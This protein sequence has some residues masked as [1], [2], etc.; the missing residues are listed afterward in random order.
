MIWPAL[1]LL[2]SARAPAAD[3]PPDV[4]PAEQLDADLRQRSEEVQRRFQEQSKDIQ[5]RFQAIDNFYHYNGPSGHHEYR[6]DL[7]SDALPTRQF[8]SEVDQAIQLKYD[9]LEAQKNKR[10]E[11]EIKALEK[12]F[13][14][15]T[16]I[17]KG[18][19]AGKALVRALEAKMGNPNHG[20]RAGSS[21]T[22]DTASSAHPDNWG[23]LPQNPADPFGYI[24]N[25]NAKLMQND[26]GAAKSLANN[27]LALD[28]RDS[29]AYSLRAAAEMDLKDYRAA[30]SDAKSAID[31]NSGDDRS[32]AILMLAHDAVS[33][34]E[35]RMKA[36]AAGD[37][38]GGVAAAGG[39]RGAAQRLAP[40]VSQ[41][42][43]EAAVLLGE[44]QRAMSLGDYQAAIAQAS[45]AISLDDSQASA[46]ALRAMAEE[47]AGKYA[48]AARD[49]A[50][51]LS[52]DPNNRLAQNVRAKALNEMGRFSDALASADSGLR[53]NPRNAYLQYMRAMALSGRGDK[54]GALESL[55][56]AAALDPRF[57]DAVE[58]AQDAPAE[59]DLGFLFPED[60][61]A[62]AKAALAARGGKKARDWK[63]LWTLYGLGALALLGLLSWLAPALRRL[64]SQWG[65][66]RP[67]VGR[68]ETIAAGLPT[69]APTSTLATTGVV[70]RGQY[71][72]LGIIGSSVHGAV[73][74][75]L[76]LSLERRVAIRKLRAEF[77]SDDRERLLA[78]AR[79][80]ASLNHPGIAMLY[81]VLDEP[82]ALYLVSEFAPGK[83]LRDVLAVN[84]PL[85]APQALP[86]FRRLAQA[87]DHAH[88]RGAIHGGIKASN[89]MVGADSSAKL[90][91]FGLGRGPGDPLTDREAFAAC[92]REAIA[93]LS[94]LLLDLIDMSLAKRRGAWNSAA[95]VVDVVQH[96]VEAST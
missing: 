3:P 34:Q 7:P 64:L 66:T 23:L 73:Y 12:R 84:G 10:P 13:K 74:E 65:H 47:R 30:A 4:V 44:A 11:A 71:R 15:A 24:F 50:T 38:G 78:P 77:H 94:P 57:Q 5:G 31:I 92:L 2:L 16:E 86:L 55:K 41:S 52:L 14:V 37:D 1:L 85:T 8:W 46:F 58:L 61:L 87:L 9:L 89:V 45:R 43:F 83:T 67:A 19:P 68:S 39:S 17:A 88:A 82:D 63:L 48:E 72:R 49:A 21:N 54:A 62:A 26:P 70:L 40:S 91:D 81:A 28:P 93:G 95:E 6:P 32:K 56:Q 36:G 90:L 29:E 69:P 76:D 22:G 20:P 79:L 96:A 33:A 75:G 51:A 42:P 35:P 59:K 53:G 60:R 80:A 25:G 27:A 18:D